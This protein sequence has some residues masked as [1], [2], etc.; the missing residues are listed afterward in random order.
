MVETLTRR[1]DSPRRERR[2][3]LVI[4]LSAVLLLAAVAGAGGLYYNWATGASG[5]RQEV[6]LIIPTGATGADVADLLVERDVI[7]STFVFNLIARL[8]GFGSGFQAG[9]Y[10]NLTT[11]MTVNEAL[12]A[13]GEGP[14]VETVSASFPE[15]YRLEEVADRAAEQLGISAQAFRRAAR[16]GTYSIPPFLPQ[17][18]DTV[19][20]FLFPN[21][22]DFL[23]DV[24]A[25]GVIS[26]L[27]EEFETQAETLPWEQAESLGVSPYEVVTIASMIEREARVPEDRPKIARVIYNRL[28]QGMAL[29]IDATVQYA[30]GDWEPILIA[31]REVDDPYNTYMHAGLPPG[32]IASPGRASL[33]AALVPAD[34]PWIYY[35]VIDAEGHHAFTGSYQEFLRLVDQYQG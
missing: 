3:G 19:E 5:P 4:L 27:L 22:Y 2:R 16:S 31:D 14:L 10:D 12:D 7:R 1:S 17:G 13:L 20:G 11:N 9:M 29:E 23:T 24:D 30:L 35:V 25:K 34:G 8:R 32:P 18:K 21:T 26:R 15:G 33:E 28:K 6:E